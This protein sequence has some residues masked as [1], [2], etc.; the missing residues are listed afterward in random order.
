[1]LLAAG[2]LVFTGVFGWPVACALGLIGVVVS[3]LMLYAAGRHLL[4]RSD[5]GRNPRLLSERRLDAATR[6]LDR[7]G[8]WGVLIARL[9]PGTR[10]VVFIT[11]GVR[12]MPPLRFV[13]FDAA[14]A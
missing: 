2:Y 1:V 9:V 14:G 4:W 7:V 6:W 8:P 5:T 13:A 3:D 12:N 10:L 11:A